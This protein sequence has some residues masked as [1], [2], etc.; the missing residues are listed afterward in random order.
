M[1]ASIAAF[2]HSRHLAALRLEPDGE[3]SSAGRD[4]V[5]DEE[6][7]NRR[8]RRP[9]QA[10]SQPQANA[11]RLLRALCNDPGACAVLWCLCA[12]ADWL[13]PP[14]HTLLC[15]ATSLPRHSIAGFTGSWKARAPSCWY[16]I[17]MIVHG[18]CPPASTASCAASLAYIVAA[19]VTTPQ[20][21]C[22]P[23][24]NHVRQYRATPVYGA[25]LAHRRR[26][27]ANGHWCR[28]DRYSRGHG[29]E[30]RAA[31]ASVFVRLRQ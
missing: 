11:V 7:G 22:P 18:E 14:R 16:T 15:F 28:C 13:N 19:F 4:R 2:R 1:L 9:P 21:L 29:R 24:D 10:E 5:A 27:V 26:G 8:T 17:S 20:P 23:Q 12:V 3:G 25:G 31:A 6:E 30:G